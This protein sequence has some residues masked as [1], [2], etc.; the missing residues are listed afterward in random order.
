MKELL[1]I[2]EDLLL[3]VKV[4]FFVLLLEVALEVLIVAL[5]KDKVFAV[6]FFVSNHV[7]DLYDI[8]VLFQLDQRFNLLPCSRNGIFN[9]F[10]FLN[11]RRNVYHF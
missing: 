5:L 4:A 8:W 10:D 9:L 3:C 6:M 1:E 11:A 7:L 2:E